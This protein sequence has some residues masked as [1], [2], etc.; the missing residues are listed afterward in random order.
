MAEMLLIIVLI[1]I[2]LIFA[3]RRLTRRGRQMAMLVSRGTVVTGQVVKAERKRLSRT[4]DAFMLRYS[5]V[6]SGGIEYEREIEV[7]PKDFDNY[8]EGQAIDVVYDPAAPE[9]N[10]LKDA[11]DVARKAMNR[12]PA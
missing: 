1:V 4:H 7:M 8:V 10:M 3:W 5:F 2:G 11:V 6:S 9:V 12:M